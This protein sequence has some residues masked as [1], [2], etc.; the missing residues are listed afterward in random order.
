MNPN[1]SPGRRPVH[2]KAGSFSVAIIALLI[3]VIA[4]F[5]AIGM[6][7][8]SLF[9]FQPVEETDFTE[10]P[11]TDLSSL[12]ELT[13]SGSTTVKQISDLLAEA[14]METHEN[15][16]VTVAGGGSGA[17]ISSAGMGIVN[18]GST[19]R[20]VTD[21]ELLKYPDLQTHIIG[22]SAVIVI[23]NGIEG[24]F[25]DK[26]ELI[27]VFNDSDG[28]VNLVLDEKS[29]EIRV[30]QAGSSFQVFQR[31]DESG[32]EE[33][34]ASYLGLGKNL[35]DCGAEGRLGNK[36][37]LAAVENTSNSIAFVDF[38]FAERSQKVSIAGIESYGSAEIKASNIRAALAGTAKPFPS[39]NSTLTRPL[40][41]LTKGKPDP[42]EQGFIDFARSPDA[43]IFFKECGYFAITE[44]S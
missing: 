31:S 13:I 21:E 5:A 4:A 32:T 25:T 14:F 3:V 37:V 1:S 36:G 39:E 33:I 12:S 18:I 40:N 22:W 35:D 15:C 27:K 44:I 23:L 41:Y 6:I 42:L 10:A 20:T 34:F 28:K 8:D 30:N 17:G 11:D 2:L 19:S 26:N 16:M 9:V 7:E 43:V 29:G 38:G 24:N